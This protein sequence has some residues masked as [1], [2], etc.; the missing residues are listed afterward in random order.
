MSTRNLL[1]ALV[2]ASAF[3]MGTAVAQSPGL[4]Q[5]IS[6][7]DIKAWDIAVLPDGNIIFGKAKGGD[8]NT[9]FFWMKASA[10]ANGAPGTAPVTSGATRNAADSRKIFAKASSASRNSGFLIRNGT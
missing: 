8:E 4:G 7:A 3:D 10:P 6:E 5:N 9:Q 1:I 2:A